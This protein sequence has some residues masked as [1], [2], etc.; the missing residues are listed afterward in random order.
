MENKHGWV[1]NKGFSNFESHFTIKPVLYFYYP[2]SLVTIFKESRFPVI[3][4]QTWWCHNQL[5]NKRHIFRKDRPI[6]N[7]FTFWFNESCFK[8]FIN[9]IKLMGFQK[10]FNANATFTRITL[11]N[12]EIQILIR[13]L[14]I[15][16]NVQDLLF[17]FFWDSS[18]WSF[19]FLG[20][21]YTNPP[22]PPNSP[23][24]NMDHTVFMDY[25]Q[26]IFE[27]CTKPLS[28][29][30]LWEPFYILVLNY[31]LGKRMIGNLGML[32]CFVCCWCWIS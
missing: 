26:L 8:L 16:I 9:G 19:C 14:Y 28:P 15:T 23:L 3:G 4:K 17:K 30:D 11:Y 12:F 10:N 18:K 24:K 31:P 13:W 32:V 1:S 25:N 5:R 7:A 29:R 27:N 21:F 20:F 6:F 2:A 22:Q